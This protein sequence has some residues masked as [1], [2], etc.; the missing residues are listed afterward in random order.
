MKDIPFERSFA[1]HP[2]SKYWSELNELK[3]QEAFKSTNKKFWFNCDNCCHK[4]EIIL[5][6]ITNLHRWCPYCSKPPNMLC[7]NDCII[8]FEKS[9]ASHPKS[10]YWSSKNELNPRQVFKSSNTKFWFNCNECNHEFECALNNINAGKWCSYCANKILCENDNCKICFDKSFA[11][12]PKSKFWNEQN[13][14]NPKQVFNSSSK[15][16]IFNCFV[17]K[18]VFE[19][20]INN[21]TNKNNMTWCPYCKNK[22]ELKLFNWLKQQNYIVKSQIRF[23]WCK[24]QRTLP[25]DF[26]LEQYK[27]II[28]LDGPQH[29]K[30]IS[31]WN[32]PEDTKIKDDLKNTLSLENGYSLIRICQII[33][34]NDVENWRNQLKQVIKKYDKPEL[35]K[36]GN[37]YN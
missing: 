36:I 6:N 29:F 18:N 23:N 3:P 35:I 19:S 11:S 16:F 1:S 9:F 24:N 26:V 15:K 17:C 33:V 32:S 5:S 21:I 27:L 13:K 34:F 2:K 10:T 25:F 7:E 12:H 30:Q 4:F 14:V 20:S 37:I 8:C 31:N 22:T 28:E